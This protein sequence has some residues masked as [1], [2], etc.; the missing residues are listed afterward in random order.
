MVRGRIEYDPPRFMTVDVAAQQIMEVITG[1]AEADHVIKPESPCIGVARIG[2][3]SQQMI[4]LPLQEMSSADLG[5]PL[6]SLVIP[7]AELH[8][9]ESEFVSKAYDQLVTS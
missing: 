9:L 8:P 4:E 2:S 6:H 5:E 3:D 1:Q 7:A